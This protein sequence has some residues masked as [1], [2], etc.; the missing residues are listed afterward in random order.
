VIGRDTPAQS[1]RGGDRQWDA[2][3]PVQR[4]VVVGKPMREMRSFNRISLQSSICRAKE[5]LFYPLFMVLL[6][7]GSVSGIPEI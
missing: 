5:I 2:E 6:V 7:E 3:T 1:L 4:N